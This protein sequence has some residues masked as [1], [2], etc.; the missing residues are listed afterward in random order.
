MR[1]LRMLVFQHISP[2]VNCP[3]LP[4]YFNLSQLPQFPR[5]RGPGGGGAFA[6]P[7]HAGLPAYFTSSQLPESSRI[8]HRSSR[9]FHLK[10]TT[11]VFQD[12][13]PV[14]QDVSPYVSYPNFHVRGDLAEEE[15]VRDLGMLVFQHVSPQVYCPSIPGCF[16]PSQLPQLGPR[17]ATA[18]APKPLKE[19]QDR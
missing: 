13:A 3:S 7:W 12:I 14:F 15:Q 9:I 16:T 18:R 11:P 8:F 17:S 5:E 4:A 10:L 2:Q 1:C 6:R 19:S